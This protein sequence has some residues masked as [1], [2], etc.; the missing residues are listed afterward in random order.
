MSYSKSDNDLAPPAM[1]QEGSLNMTDLS[2]EQPTVT[3]PEC[4]AERSSDTMLT[5][6]KRIG[7]LYSHVTKLLQSLRNLLDH[8]ENILVSEVLDLQ[9]RIKS[10]HRNCSEFVHEFCNSLDKNSELVKRYMSQLQDRECEI[11]VVDE[12]V[13]VLLLQ[14]LAVGSKKSSRHSGPVRSKIHSRSE[15]A[16]MRSGSSLSESARA[17]MEMRYAEINLEKVRR[18][19]AL[20]VETK[21]VNEQSQRAILQAE[22]ELAFAKVRSEA[23]QGL[24]DLEEDESY[25]VQEKVSQYVSSLHQFMGNDTNDQPIQSDPSPKMGEGDLQTP[26]NYVGPEASVCDSKTVA[27]P[28]VIVS[29]SRPLN[30]QAA[31]WQGSLP[32]SVISGFN[33]STPALSVF[34]PP[35]LSYPV[36]VAVTRIAKS[37]SV[38]HRPAIPSSAVSFQLPRPI[39]STFTS[40]VPT[41]LT[42]YTT[43]TA[44]VSSV[45][46]GPAVTIPV[47]PPSL[48]P[49]SLPP[50]TSQNN[51]FQPQPY[52][53]PKSFNTSNLGMST[54]CQNST[55]PTANNLSM[56]EFAR[57]FVRCQGSRALL[58]NKKYGGDPLRYHQFM[59][60]V[61]DRILGIYAKSDPGHALQLLLE[62]TTGRARKLISSCIMLRPTEALSKALELLYTSFGSPA[63]AVKAHLKAVCEGL[64]VR[65]DERNLQDFYSDLVNC[66]MVVEA[67]NSTHMLNSAA[68]SESLFTRLPK[69]L[70]RQFAELALRKGYDMEVV[71][72]DLFI[73]FIDQTRR[74]SSSRLGRLMNASTDKVAP[75][76]Q[77]WSKPKT[78][79]AYSAQLDVNRTNPSPA[80]ETSKDKGY[81]RKCSACDAMDH[82]IWH[83]SKFTKEPVDKRYSIVNQKRLC[84]NCL[85]T[86]H[87]VKDCPCKARCRICAKTHQS[88]LHCSSV[89][90]TPDRKTSSATSAPTTTSSSVVTSSIHDVSSDVNVS[91]DKRGVRNRLQVLPVFVVNPTT[92]KNQKTWALLDTGA[93]T[94]LLTHNLFS[95]L[96]LCGTPIHSRLQLA[97]GDIKTFDTEETSCMI[98]DIDGNVSFHLEEVNVVDRLPNLGG[99]IPSSDNLLRHEHLADVHIPDIDENEVELIIG[100]GSPELHVFSEVRRG[101][102]TKP[103]AGKS[104]LGW[105]L[106]GRD[107]TCLEQEP[108][109]HVSLIT[110]Q[111]LDLVSDAICPCQFDHADLFTDS[112]ERLPSQDDERSIDVMKSSCELRDGHYSMRLP[113]RDGCPKLPNNYNMALSRL[114][115]LGR[116]LKREP[117]NLTLYQD[118]VNEMVQ[119]GH[120][121]R[122][123]QDDKD[124][125]SERTWY[126]PHH[127]I[128]KKFRI[129]FDCAA[130]CQGTSLNQQLLQGPDN[131][132]SLIGVLLRFR[133]YSVAIV[134]DIRNMFHMVKVDPKDQSALRFLW[135]RDGDPDKSIESYHLT[136]HTFGLTSSPSI[137]GY[138]LRRTAHQNLP[139]ASELALSTI[140]NQFYVDD[141]LTSVK[142]SNQAVQLISELDSV[143]SSGGFTLAKFASN[144][145]EVLE[146]L[147]RDRL[148]PQLQVINF[149]ADNLPTHKTLGLIWHAST[150]QLRV[151]VAVAEHPRTRRGLLSVLASVYDP[152]G[153][154]GPYTLPAKLILQQLAKAEL[155]WD[156]DIPD[157]AKSTWNAWLNA[158][159]NLDGLSIPRVYVGFENAQNLQLHCFADAS[160]DGFGA[161]CYLCCNDGDKCFGNF[162]M[163][164]SRVAPMNQQS[165]PRLELCAAA[166]AVRLSSIV[167]KELQVKIDKVHFWT[168]STTVLSYLNNTSKRRPAF[169]TNR[170]DTIRK[171]TRVDQWRWI[172]TQKNPADLYSRGVSPRQLHKAEKWLNAPNFLLNDESSWPSLDDCP[173]KLSEASAI[174]QLDK[175]GRTHGL[176]SSTTCHLSTSSTSTVPAVLIRLTT[177]FSTLQRAVK[178]TAWLLRAKQILQSRVKDKLALS[179]ANDFIGA[180]EYD[181]ALLTLI[182]VVQQQEFPHLVE[183]LEVYPS[184]EVAKGKAGSIPKQAIQPLLKYCP[185]ILDGVIRVGGR[186]QRSSQPKDFRHP[187][188]LPKSHH[189][190]GLIIQ[191]HHAEMGHNSS[192]Y[193]LNTL[194]ARYHVIGQERTVKR[195]IKQ[196]C[197]V[198]RNRSAAFGLQ[199]MAPLPPARVEIGRSAFENCGIDFMG[200]L[201]VKQARNS[202]K[203]Y[204]C[205]FTCLASRATHLEMA[206]SLTTE[207]FLMVLRRFLST[208]GYSTHTIFCDNGTNFVGARS[209]LQRGLQRLNR[210]QIIQE[211][212]PKGIEWVHAPPLASHQGGIYESIIRLVRKAMDSLLSDRQI[213]TLTDEGLVTVLKEIEYILN[214]RP[215]ARVSTSPEDMETLSPIMLLTGSL[216][217]GLP[218]DVFVSSDSMRSSWR[219]CQLQIDL[220]WERWQSEYLQLLQRRQKWLMPERNLKKND[221]VLIKDEDQPRNFW[222]KGLVVEVF[223][224]RDGLVRKAKIRLATGKIYLRDIRKLCLL[225]GDIDDANTTKGD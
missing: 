97:N 129:V 96:D 76:G 17:R 133:F 215:L 155:G 158:L 46:H 142:T 210:Q 95:E 114:K 9:S 202:L 100:T 38:F 211:L 140:Q 108:I 83:C 75:Q 104:P 151:K 119:L 77:R 213:R 26:V 61:E 134:G 203:R 182:R 174:S 93:D 98:T 181:N 164:R 157:E 25:S 34:P 33:D 137:A 110:T 121:K 109:N 103:W 149:H 48:I 10:A 186:L 201:E 36:S 4:S 147:P 120:A 123:S 178:S 31:P 180:Q 212:S 40:A 35:G 222:P 130:T 146:T 106:F 192:S 144:R 59:R 187:I 53:D 220:F 11:Q 14:Q 57:V 21:R 175:S 50:T 42:T 150:D 128:K 127:Y 73:E 71:P 196:M 179:L 184:H 78:T 102:A 85:G 55:S 223:P 193:V 197:M 139:N 60:Q 27:A 199:L 47:V 163:G 176:Q 111:R 221:L 195:Y 148:T 165:I 154:V 135:W 87:V 54:L 167:L 185:I 41:G 16:S 198:C 58:E 24:L 90:T 29:K 89:A 143:L 2:S 20:I 205:V 204:C 32:K 72:F 219:A 7:G 156:V 218:P 214:C 124:V 52:S 188:V 8:D 51:V 159:P 39:A 208:R 3:L 18:E 190:T 81:S 1:T 209:E 28:E 79:R 225:E 5:A 170:I 82:W 68:T 160:K 101:D 63:V 105:V 116:R 166:T 91:R 113:W 224:D 171:G 153:I 45:K 132:N 191:Y 168:D 49:G 216:A 169:E 99:S 23:A 65:T 67:A 43:G 115:S 107:N 86:G 200:P 207:S 64:P 19:Q 161:V 92:G 136:V 15:K 66:K 152:F 118:K 62:S 172:N 183:A 173:S 117:N 122:A 74:L 206:Y 189:F 194:R 88:L 30:I 69:H 37:N 217:T 22:S 94:H 162:V 131:T 12:R 177:R 125:P 141:L 84:Y 112:D 70:Q 6:A 145:P 44:A 13:T 56:D 80:K 138:A 126:I